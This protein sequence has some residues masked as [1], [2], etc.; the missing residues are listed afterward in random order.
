MSHARNLNAT[1]LGHRGVQVAVVLVGDGPT[2]PPTIGDSL[3][4]PVL[5]HCPSDPTTAE[6]SA[7]G[8][9]TSR[10]ARSRLAERSP[11]SATSG[12]QPAARC[13]SR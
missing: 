5:G 7:T 11:R 9:T 8:G 3:G 1:N 4:A 13:R 6:T 2:G 12:R 10:L